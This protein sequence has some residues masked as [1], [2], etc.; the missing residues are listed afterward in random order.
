MEMEMEMEMKGLSARVP[1]Q[2]TV[3]MKDHPKSFRK[4]QRDQ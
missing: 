2:H 1:T 4:A 3:K